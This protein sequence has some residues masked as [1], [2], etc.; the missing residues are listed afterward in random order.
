LDAD[1]VG[2]NYP[3][4]VGIVADARAALAALSDRLLSRSAESGWGGLLEQARAARHPRPEWLIEVLREELPEDVP[5]FTDACEMGYRMQADWPSYGPRGF[6]YPSNYI[7]LGWAF[8]AAL[9][10]AVAREGGPVVSVSGDGGFV[11]TAQE[12]ATA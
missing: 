10:A 1:Q 9:G 7:T 12:L 5:V 2:M 8:P 3:V 6:F 4:A 11:M